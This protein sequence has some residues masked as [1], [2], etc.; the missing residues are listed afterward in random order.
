MDFLYLDNMFYKEADVEWLDHQ[1][2]MAKKGYN[3]NPTESGDNL[4]SPP[5]EQY[6]RLMAFIKT[7]EKFNCV[8]HRFTNSIPLLLFMPALTS[9]FG[10]GG[11]NC[12]AR[13]GKPCAS[14]V[15]DPL[16]TIVQ[17]ELG[18][19]PGCDGRFA[20]TGTYGPI[21][22]RVDKAKFL[23]FVSMDNLL[24]KWSNFKIMLAT[25]DYCHPDSD[26]LAMIHL[27]AKFGEFNA[28][29]IQ[30]LMTFMG[31]PHSGALF[32]YYDLTSDIY[33][34]SCD[35]P[36]MK[37]FPGNTNI[38]MDDCCVHAYT[39]EKQCTDNI[40]ENVA[41]VYPGLTVFS[42]QENNS[43]FTLLPWQELS[44]PLEVTIDDDRSPSM[45]LKQQFDSISVSA[46]KL[47]A[48]QTGTMNALGRG[49]YM[50]VTPSV[51]SLFETLN[52][53]TNWLDHY[54]PVAC[55]ATSIIPTME[56]VPKSLSGDNSPDLKNLEIDPTARFRPSRQFPTTQD[57]I[58]GVYTLYPYIDIP[59]QLPKDQIDDTIVQKNYQKLL[60]LQLKYYHDVDYHI[61]VEVTGM[62]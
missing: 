6:N 58:A 32:G 8:G 54:D 13:G 55:A 1:S 47:V 18:H 52:T 42:R 41:K 23:E 17:K 53:K 34:S 37:Q 49:C 27:L 38:T 35:Y 11:I 12:A 40:K 29:G 10:G 44:C 25:K 43:K 16:D 36:F 46:S 21:V 51:N 31:A 33:G 48:D 20:Q 60:S 14:Q 59:S 15:S 61:K 45:S 2:R 4:K 9:Y 26:E 5:P 62:L 39:T 7:R 30:N 28:S 3:F 24:K 57:T 22:N 56:F 19:G 50:C